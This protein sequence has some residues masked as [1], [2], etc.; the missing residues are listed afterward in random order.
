[1]AESQAAFDALVDLA[2]RSRRS[3][4]GL[5]SQTKVQPQ[6]SG[7]GFTLL[8]QHFV[9]PLGEVSELLE[10]PSYTRLPGVQP[11]V[12]GVANVRG[13]L[14]PLLDLATFL[15]GELGGARKLHRVLVLEMDELYAGLVVDSALGMQHFPTDSFSVELAS[16]DEQVKPYVTG[17]YTKTDGDQPWYVFSPARLSDDPQFLNAAG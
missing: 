16:L 6:W 10:F 13:R 8:G 7:I 1:M 9:A 17:S 15:G 5:P 2:Q 14:L 12:L 4:K 3:A 11:W